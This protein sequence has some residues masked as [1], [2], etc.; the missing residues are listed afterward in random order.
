MAP[1]TAPPMLKTMWL[2]RN[3]LVVTW[4]DQSARSVCGDGWWVIVP[5]KK[6]A[7]KTGVA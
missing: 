4:R 2:K 6:V 1:K 5:A 7:A 3:S